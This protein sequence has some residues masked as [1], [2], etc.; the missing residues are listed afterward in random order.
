M[1]GKQPLGVGGQN[2]DTSSHSLPPLSSKQKK[3]K[4][5]LAE[6]E[7]VAALCIARAVQCAAACRNAHD[8]RRLMR[9]SFRS[10]ESHLDEGGGEIR[11][12]YRMEMK[13]WNEL[14]SRIIHSHPRGCG[15]LTSSPNVF[16]Q[17]PTT[18]LAHS[19]VRPSLVRSWPA[20]REI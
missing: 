19:F 9:R 8:K 20:F 1:Q 17:A 12:S 10:R 4:F 13:A 3:G 11:T 2:E 16:N 14:K 6:M 15:G 7:S 18:F 5:A